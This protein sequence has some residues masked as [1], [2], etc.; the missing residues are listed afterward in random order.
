MQQSTPIGR[1]KP[2][3]QIFFVGV[4]SQTPTMAKRRFVSHCCVTEKIPL[5]EDSPR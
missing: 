1:I 5:N 4:A 2:G 3:K